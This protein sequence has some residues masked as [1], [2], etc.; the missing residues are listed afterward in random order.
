MHCVDLG[1]SF[2]TSIYL[3]ILASI[4]PITSLVKCARSP[5]T[6]PPGRPWWLRASEHSR[7]RVACK[8]HCE[9]SAKEVSEITPSDSASQYG[10]EEAVSSLL[11]A[12]LQPEEYSQTDVC[13]NDTEFQTLP[14]LK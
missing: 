7:F 13:S 5:R 4:Q 11:V 10:S 14:D 3:Q 6:D 9:A 1:E 12:H 8:Q 2:P